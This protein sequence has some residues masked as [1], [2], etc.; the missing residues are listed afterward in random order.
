MLKAEIQDDSEEQGHGKQHNPE[1]DGQRTSTGDSQGNEWESTRQSWKHTGNVQKYTYLDQPRTPLVS[2]AFG[3]QYFLNPVYVFAP[4][5]CIP[6]FRGE[7]TGTTGV[8]GNGD[9]ALHQT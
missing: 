1:K 9:K 8:R 4:S 2:L 7:S 3:S 6:A 5:H